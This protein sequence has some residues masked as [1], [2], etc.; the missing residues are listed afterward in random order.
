MRGVYVG[1]GKVVLEKEMSVVAEDVKE[2]IQMAVENLQKL[3]AEV[4]N[5]GESEKVPYYW[6][7]Q[8]YYMNKEIKRA[9]TQMLMGFEEDL[10][11]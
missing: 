1:E 4:E 3:M 2:Q 8:F 7:N 6:A 9:H 11:Y 5:L 10:Y